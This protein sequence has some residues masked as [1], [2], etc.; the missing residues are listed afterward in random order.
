MD[1]N[2]EERLREAKRLI[3]E[4]VSSDT[5]IRHGVHV[6]KGTRFPVSRIFAEI[7][8]GKTIKSI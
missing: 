4:S 7:A 3:D 2:T 5:N 6:L 8:D 1:D